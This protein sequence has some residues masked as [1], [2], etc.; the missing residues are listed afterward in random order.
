MPISDP[1]VGQPDPQPLRVHEADLW[2]KVDVDGQSIDIE[3]GV[4][5][6]TG[7]LHMRVNRYGDSIEYVDDADISVD[8]QDLI[9]HDLTSPQAVR[10]R[11][12]L[13]AKYTEQ[14]IEAVKGREV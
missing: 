6:V 1:R 12:Q 5:A 11:S 8:L 9:D 10:L 4:F 3:D 14:A 13:I 7:T 2:Y